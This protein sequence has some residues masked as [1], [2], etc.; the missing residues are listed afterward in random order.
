MLAGT[1]RGICVEGSTEPPCG[2]RDICE[3]AGTPC[4][5]RWVKGGEGAGGCDRELSDC[6]SEG[7]GS[8]AGEGWEESVPARL[9]GCV[10]CLAVVVKDGL[11]EWLLPRLMGWA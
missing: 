3:G 10:G 8:G 9:I 1:A 5:E 2:G 11:M 4:T 6:E 7:C